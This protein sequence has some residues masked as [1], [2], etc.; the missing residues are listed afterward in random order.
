MPQSFDTLRVGHKYVM[1]NQGEK[2]RFTILEIRSETDM[3][4]KDLDTL[5]TYNILDLIKYGIGEDYDLF[6]I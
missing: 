3:L 1:I 2:V 6:E 4:L 5:E